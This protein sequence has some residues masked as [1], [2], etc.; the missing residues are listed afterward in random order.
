VKMYYGSTAMQIGPIE[1]QLSCD[2]P[3]TGVM[4]QGIVAQQ[5]PIQQAVNMSNRLV[6]RQC[7]C[8]KSGRFVATNLILCFTQYMYKIVKLNSLVPS[9]V[10]T[11]SPDPS[12]LVLGRYYNLA[13]QLL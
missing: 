4:T 2:P 13:N 6:Q 5:T 10:S 7:L 3:A 1:L 8:V 9:C 12:S 11:A